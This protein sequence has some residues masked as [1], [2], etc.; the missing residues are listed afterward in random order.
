M[1]GRAVRKGD[2]KLVALKDE[3][4]RLYDLSGDRTEMN[5]LAAKF[6]E[7]VQ[8]MSQA[9]EQWGKEVGLKS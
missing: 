7:R 3:P 9:W 1:G 8:A 6:P 2:W 5:D 4:W